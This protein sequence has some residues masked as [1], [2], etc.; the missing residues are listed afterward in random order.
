MLKTLVLLIPIVWGA[1]LYAADAVYPILDVQSG[2]LLGGSARGK[3]L[4][5]DTAARAMRGGETYRSY[6]LNYLIATARGGLPKTEGPPCPETSFVTLS[7]RR[8]TIAVGGAWNAL[9]RVPK[10][11]S[12]TQP[13]YRAAVTAILRKHG[14]VRPQVHIT[15][16][17]RVDLDGD[18]E[19]EVLLTATHGLQRSEGSISTGSTSGSYS[20]SLLRKVVNGKVKTII[21]GENY[22]PK[23]RTFNAPTVYK[24]A[25]V[26]DLNGDEK[27]E[28]VMHARYYEGASTTVYEVRDNKAIEVLNA[29]CGA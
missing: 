14:I 4:K 18:G 29:G 24:I 15:Q 9:P 27:M 21:L 22:F 25:A 13:V 20:F 19:A 17:L 26:L 23:A 7:P 16:I 28:I 6:G 1:P 11:E 3:W 8:G 5:A 12:R 2:Y 10:I